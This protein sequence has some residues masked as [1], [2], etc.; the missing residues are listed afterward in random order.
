M[1]GKNYEEGPFAPFR[2]QSNKRFFAPG[3][4]YYAKLL[5]EIVIQSTLTI[6]NLIVIIII[7]F[8]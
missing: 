1:K 2:N 8:S 7:L 3:Y 5:F 6:D 4:F